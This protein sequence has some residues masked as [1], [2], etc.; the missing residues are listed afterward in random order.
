M[1]R[2][3]VLALAVYFVSSRSCDPVIMTLQQFF[4]MASYLAMATMGAALLSIVVAWFRVR[5]RAGSAENLPEDPEGLF[6]KRVADLRVLLEQSRLERWLW[7]VVVLGLDIAQYTVGASMAGSTAA[8]LA[9]TEAWR[10]SSGTTGIYGAIIII[11]AI[12]HRRFK[13]DQQFTTARRRIPALEGLWR[14][15]EEFKVSL[16]RVEQAQRDERFLEQSREIG[17]KIERIAE[18]SALALGDDEP[19]TQAKD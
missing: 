19:A 16:A 17:K 6:G 14:D 18:A 8:D 3:T 2:P 11:A 5:A 7:G 1:A 9:G 15:I 13:P 12:A 10:M 4:E